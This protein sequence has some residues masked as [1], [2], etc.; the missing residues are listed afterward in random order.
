MGAVWG[1]QADVF[2]EC[3]LSENVPVFVY[4]VWAAVGK[5]DSQAVCDAE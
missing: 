5:S 1:V 4:F 2:D 3:D